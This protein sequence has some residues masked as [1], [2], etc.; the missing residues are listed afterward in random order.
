MNTKRVLL[1][2]FV[3]VVVVLGGLSATTVMSNAEYNPKTGEK[4]QTDFDEA[5]ET[6]QSSNDLVLV[7]FWSSNCQYCEQFTTRLQNDDDLQ[8][9]V[10]QYVMVS[11]NVKKQQDLMSRY[12]VDSYPTLVVVRPNGT[13]VASF[14][15][16]GVESPA[17]RLYTI[18]ESAQ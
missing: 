14:N 4:W 6:A 5:L 1:V 10:D 15:P 11:A 3:L 9:A 17:N 13:A 18:S 12:G 16:V 8:R 2:A 7:Y